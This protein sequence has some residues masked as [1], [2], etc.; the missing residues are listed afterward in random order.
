[1]TPPESPTPRSRR[2][3]DLR[4]VLR[5]GAIVVAAVL[6][7]LAIWK[8]I[9][10][11]PSRVVWLQGLVLPT[12]I[13]S[14]VVLVAIRHEI[15]WIRPTRRLLVLMDEIR[16][17]QAP[18]EELSQVGGG[19]AATATALKQ[20]FHDLRQ[21]R[22]QLSRL[23]EEI[24]QRVA[25]RT[26]ALER[27]VGSLREQAS[28]DALTGLRNRR[29][30]DEQYPLVFADARDREIDLCVLMIDV[31]HFK[32]LND[33]LG[34]ARGDEL[35]RSIGQLIRS[36][37][38][39]DD[40]AYRYGG[41]EFVVLLP[42]ASEAIGERLSARL[43]S[44]VSELVKPLRL[45]TPPGLSIGVAGRLA[46]SPTTPEQLLAAADARLYAVKRARPSPG[47]QVA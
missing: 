2:W 39:D 27:K 35:L 9:V 43:R 22:Q 17:G 47:R 38:R 41:D 23:Q 3:I 32:P 24:R 36:S 16:G 13:L 7:W 19:P 6:T 15:R 44:L 1:M 5:C 45:A 18:I 20:L 37:I 12:A 11:D 46:T 40:L 31:D 29:A 8:L 42:G 30:W 28:R 26:D 21:Q 4:L 14:L 33:T 25:S 10:G 34:H